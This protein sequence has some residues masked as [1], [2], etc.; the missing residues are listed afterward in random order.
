MSPKVVTAA[1]VACLATAGCNVDAPAPGISEASARALRPARPELAE[2]YDRSCRSCHTIA[3][4]GAPLTG[5]T[6]AWATRLE[7]GMDTMVQSVVNGSG[8]M[9][10]LGLCM[11]C[12]R[13][14][15]E[16]LIRFMASG[17]GN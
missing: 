9:P 16:A 13:D 4:T 3:G 11:D 2:V 15:F 17:P 6:Q 1:I 8:G 10:P 14:Q 12:D 5:D 7:V